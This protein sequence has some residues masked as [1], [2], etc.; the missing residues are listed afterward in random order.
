VFDNGEAPARHIGDG[1]YLF[2]TNG[3]LRTSA[4]Y[5]CVL[6]CADP[7]QGKI[8]I[9]AQPKTPESIS[10]T[11]VSSETIDLGGHVVKLHLG[12]ARHRFIFGFP[13]AVGTLLAPGETLALLPDGRGALASQ[14]LKTLD[15]GRGPNVMADGG[16]TVSLRSASDIV[17]A[18]DAW[19]S[20]RC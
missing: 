3:A 8:A 5:P 7:L 4:T 9:Q 20:A 2:S 18:C 14:G 15:L 10:V 1:G 17:V 12:G 19:G 11:N 6:D 13:F 16:N